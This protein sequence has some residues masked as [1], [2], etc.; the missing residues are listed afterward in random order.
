MKLLKNILLIIAIV[1][2]GLFTAV[3]IYVRFNQEEIKKD[4]LAS[5]NKLLIK[6]VEV[7]TVDFSILNNFPNVSLEFN[8]LKVYSKEDTLLSLRKLSAK[9]SIIDIYYGRYNLS[10]IEIYD[11]NVSIINEKYYQNYILWEQDSISDSPFNI[12][13]RN[14][15]SENVR[16]SLKTHAGHHSFAIIDLSLKVKK[17][18]DFTSF[19][20][21]GN[22][23]NLRITVAEDSYNFE[24]KANVDIHGNWDN[25]N[26][27]L[28]FSKTK[29]KI[30]GFYT[31]LDGSINFKSAADFNL[32]F[33]LNDVE[34]E[35]LKPFLNEEYFTQISDNHA[36]GIFDFKGKIVG[37]WSKTSIPKLDIKYFLKDGSWGK[38]SSLIIIENAKGKLENSSNK[39]ILF[40]DTIEASYFD[41][42]IRGSGNVSEFSKP[43]YKGRFNFSTDIE[44]LAPVFKLDRN[45]SLSGKVNGTA[46]LKGEINEIENYSY[47][48]WKKYKQNVSIEVADLN[49][50]YDSTY[51]IEET[52]FYL[53]C[54]YNNLTLDSI[55]GIIQKQ[56]ILAQLDISNFYSLFDTGENSIISGKVSSP[57]LI[58]ENWLNWPI[59]SEEES[60]WSPKIFLDVKADRLEFNNAIAKNV[61]SQLLIREDHLFLKDA[62]LNVFNGSIRGDLNYQF[63]NIQKSLSSKLIGKKLDISLLFKEYNNFGQTTLT[64]KNLSG[65]A[66]LEL[67]FYTEFDEENNV[68]SKSIIAHSDIEVV[69]GRLKDFEPIYR[70]SKFIELEELKDIRFDTLRN[71]ILIKDE[72]VYIPKFGIKNTALDIVMEGTHNFSNQVD[73]SFTLFLGEIL[74]KKIKK[75]PNEDM[76]Y[77]EDDGL[78]R[79]RIFIKMKGDISSPEIKYDKQGLKEHWN[80]EIKEEKQEI[81]SILNKEFGMFKKD[82]TLNKKKIE[83][84]EKASPF[85]IEWEEKEKKAPKEEIKPNSEDKKSSKKGK[86]GKFID[87][88]AKPNEEEYVNPPQ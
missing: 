11:G 54:Q 22:V 48:T 30:A 42:N 63:G 60:K 10:G 9:F 26:K 21:F 71:Q 16:F 29:T 80:K 24:D 3:F 64:D 7:K 6:K 34:P 75:N 58:I 18:E 2:F 62:Y 59:N 46:Y 35:K 4:I 32:N 79:S 36:K 61:S 68:I 49:V 55:N 27:I 15:K 50:K 57:S 20:L 70:L 17:K 56:K 8:E 51:I 23:S 40:V 45:W 88:I 87:K 66:S 81:R 25:Q 44:K 78:G 5:I 83:S 41:L 39:F 19:S 67:D 86:V 47:S 14:L 72:V 28:S 69:N 76:G 77:I 33:A 85:V 13:I 43:I 82:T 73:Y 53:N 38:D 74:K 37:E 84:E 52:S 1:I 31:D 65:D 12:D